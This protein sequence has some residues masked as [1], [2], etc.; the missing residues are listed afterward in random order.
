MHKQMKR[1][2]TWGVTVAVGVAALSL[3]VSANADSM[4]MKKGHRLLL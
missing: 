3:A 1:V 2:T 4:G